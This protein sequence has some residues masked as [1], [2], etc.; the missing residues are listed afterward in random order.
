MHQKHHIIISYLQH[1]KLESI[2]FEI[3]QYHFDAI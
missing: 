2:L 1:R 3:Y